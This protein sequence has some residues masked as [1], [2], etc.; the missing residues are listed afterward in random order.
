MR[1]TSLIGWI[2]PPWRA[3]RTTAAI[4]R[5][6]PENEWQAYA[7]AQHRQLGTCLSVIVIKKFSR[8]ALLVSCAAQH[9]LVI[10]GVALAL[11]DSVEWDILGC[12]IAGYEISYLSVVTRFI[13]KLVGL[14]N[15]VYYSR[16]SRLLEN[17]FDQ[18]LLLARYECCQEG[19]FRGLVIYE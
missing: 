7:R 4:A 19:R 13:S 15:E 8:T 5:T 6:S 12:L 17:S 18:K 16:Q 2:E 3:P 10:E 14:Y 1:R 11:E 9:L